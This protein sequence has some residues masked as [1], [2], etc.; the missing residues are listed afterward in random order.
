MENDCIFCKISKGEIPSKK[1]YENT[2]FFSIRDI[3][4]V[5]EGH[6]LTISKEHFPTILDM[7]S[8]LGGDLI[9]CL[10]NTTTELIKEKQFPGFNILQNNFKT[11]GQLVDH[12][13]FHIIPRR[14][15]DGLKNLA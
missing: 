1:I 10:K 6:A 8:N 14:E 3:H 7:P 15:G 2:N 9:D 12:L 5:T 4:P 13:H 11:A